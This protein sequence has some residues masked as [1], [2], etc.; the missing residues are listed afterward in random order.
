[1]TRRAQHVADERADAQIGGDM[2]RQQVVI[3][4]GRKPSERCGERRTEQPEQK[5]YVY[6]RARVAPHCAAQR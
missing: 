1:M 3:V 4:E 6:R 5:R 2:R